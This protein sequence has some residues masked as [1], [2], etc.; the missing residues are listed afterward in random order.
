MD[1]EGKGGA[2]EEA[3]AALARG[4]GELVTYDYRTPEDVMAH[5]DALIAAVRAEGLE[6]AARTAEEAVDAFVTCVGPARGRRP[7]V[8]AADTCGRLVVE[9]IRALKVPS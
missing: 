8:Q 2:V 9:R 4:L 3:R 1:K 7:K 5:A 6:E